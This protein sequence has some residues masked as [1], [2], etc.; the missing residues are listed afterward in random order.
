[1]FIRNSVSL[2]VLKQAWGVFMMNLRVPTRVNL[3][4]RI[5]QELSVGIVITV[6]NSHIFI[7]KSPVIPDY[8]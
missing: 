8:I 2:V 5:I 4:V 7:F 1:M 6:S 3:S